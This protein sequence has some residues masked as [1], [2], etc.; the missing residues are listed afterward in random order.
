MTTPHSVIF[1]GSFDPLH[2]G[3]LDIMRYVLQTLHAE[4]LILLPT[5][6]SP[7][8]KEFLLSPKERLIMCEMTSAYLSRCY[9]QA[10]ITACDFEIMQSK[11]TYSIESVR[12]LRNTLGDSARL[13][14]VLGWDNYAQFHLW[15]DYTILS[16]MLSLLVFDRGNHDLK[17]FNSLTQGLGLTDLEAHFIPFCS[18]ISSTHIKKQFAKKDCAHEAF[19]QIPSFLVP[20]LK[21]FLQKHLL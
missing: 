16:S 2:N 1:G 8:K 19:G 9:P 13:G 12:F 4:Q 15:K 20:T 21:D 18:A 11:P 6:C 5:F 7:F 14:F 17:S 3:H 10:H